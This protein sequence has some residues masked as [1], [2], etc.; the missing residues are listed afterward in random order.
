M[1]IRITSVSHVRTADHSFGRWCLLPRF[2]F[3]PDS[4]PSDVS[5]PAWGLGSFVPRRQTD[6][7][8]CLAARRRVQLAPLPDAAFYFQV[9]CQAMTTAAS[10]RHLVGNH[11]ACRECLVVPLLAPAAQAVVFELR[12]G[13]LV[14]DRGGSWKDIRTT[15]TTT[16]THQNLHLLTPCAPFAEAGPPRPC[17]ACVCGACCP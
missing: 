9:G 2:F 16:T 12:A 15:T 1:L 7:V 10:R 8:S 14:V 17:Y 13:S 6:P 11:P 5:S 3:L 4:G